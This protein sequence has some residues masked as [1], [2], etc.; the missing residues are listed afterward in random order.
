MAEY[1]SMF[2]MSGVA[3]HLYLGGWHLGLIP[4][5][6][7]SDLFGGP[8]TVLGIVGNLINAAVFIGK[9]WLLVFV[10]MWVRWTL[11]RLRIDQVMMTCLK[12]LVPISCFLL[13]GA[14]VS[15]LLWNSLLPDGPRLPRSVA[16]AVQA[17]PPTINPG[18]RV[19]HLP[20][21]KKSDY[22][23]HGD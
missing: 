3:V 1:G 18:A 5:N 9:A 23:L 21:L 20:R 10:M 14:T 2:A 17:E 12:Y 13:L 6:D 7:L 19:E 16:G 15:P 22:D 4:G 8:G 11:P